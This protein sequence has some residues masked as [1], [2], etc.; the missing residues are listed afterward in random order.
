MGLSC[1]ATTVYARWISSEHIGDTMRDELLCK[2]GNEE[3]ISDRFCCNLSFGTG[4][5][6]GI[7]GGRGQPQEAT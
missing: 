6:R 3:E 2:D 7:M 4:G 1:K 5:L